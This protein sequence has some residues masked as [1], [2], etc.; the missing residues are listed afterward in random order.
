MEG[1]SDE[2]QGVILGF[3]KILS[4]NPSKE[5]P[6]NRVVQLGLSNFV[7]RKQLRNITKYDKIFLS[8]L[9]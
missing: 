5:S 9:L 2:D 6:T 4:K 3:C 1:V 7:E 8:L